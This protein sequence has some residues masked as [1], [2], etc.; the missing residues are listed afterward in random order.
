LRFSISRAGNGRSLVPTLLTLALLA[1]VVT[2]PGSSS[3]ASTAAGC[4]HGLHCPT[5]NSIDIV[6]NTLTGKDVLDHSLTP[7]DF[8]GSVRGKR[9]P[10]GR[11][12]PAG[13][14]GPQGATGPAGAN[15]SNGAPGVNGAQG[16]PG[17]V[18]AWSGYSYP[19]GAPSIIPSAG[20]QVAHFVFT[21]AAAGFAV[22]S[23]DFAV[24]IHNNNT[25]TGPDCSVQTQI[26]PAPGQPDA[27][28]PG[29][30][31]QLVNANLPTQ[32]AAGTYLQLSSSTTRILPVAAGANTVYLNGKSDCLQ[33]LLGPLTMTAVFAQS[34]PAATLSVP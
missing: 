18:A 31:S 6:D 16:P 4:P 28:G 7:R 21:S 17:T 30:A 20:G 22:I 8:R 19:Q 10:A 1:L 25:G 5:F 3:T 13:P 34:N 26:A 9:G 29:F 12:G 32:L 23:A 27:A 11:Q 2:A 33:A 15:G 14:A 24:R